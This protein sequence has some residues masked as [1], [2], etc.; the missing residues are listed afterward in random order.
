MFQITGDT[1]LNGTTG[2]FGTLATTNNTNVGAPTPTVLGGTG[3]KIIIYAETSTTHPYSLG[4]N[5][6][7]L[8]YSVPFGAS[9]NFFVNGTNPLTI[10]SSSNGREP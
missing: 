8:W 3:D 7:S 6:N 9:H 1:T 4:I 2:I 5:T 10:N